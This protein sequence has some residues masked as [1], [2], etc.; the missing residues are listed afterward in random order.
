MKAVIPAAMAG[1]RNPARRPLI[2]HKTMTRDD[3][4]RLRYPYV[5]KEPKDIKLIVVAESP[6]GSS[7]PGSERYFYKP[8][9]TTEPLFAAMMKQL[10]I[11]CIKKED[12][13]QQFKKRGWVLVDATYRQV[14]KLPE[15]EA[16]R[17]IL[18]DYQLLHADL[19]G[20]T[21]DRSTPLALIKV[22]VCR[23][24]RAKLRDDGF[25]VLNGPIDI[26]FPAYGQQKRFHNQFSDLL[27]SARIR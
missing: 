27:H 3:Y 1:A 24:L 10:D 17:I 22:N 21:P 12:G 8:G 14:D 6:P 16:D 2:E 18:E 7:P 23:I 9:R 25:N 11:R 5:P 26:P 20:L 19:L 13:L 15:P 4:L